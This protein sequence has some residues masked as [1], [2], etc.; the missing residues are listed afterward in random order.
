ML[1][2]NKTLDLFWR[3]VEA[4]GLPENEA[5]KIIEEIEKKHGVSIGALPKSHDYSRHV[6]QLSRED[7]E[8][9]HWLSRNR[10]FE[11]FCERIGV[12]R[13][14]IRKACQRGNMSRQV[15]E[16]FKKGKREFLTQHS[17]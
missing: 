12:D 3:T 14:T 6:V 7:Y 9:V 5:I 16:K 8:F 11:H 17:T 10:L 1:T 13:S 4:C 15:Y 2:G